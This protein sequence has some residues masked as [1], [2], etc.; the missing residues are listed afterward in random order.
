MPYVYL[1]P[2]R[3][4][5]DAALQELRSREEELEFVKQRI[6]QLKQTIAALGPLVST[7]TERVAQTA[8]LPDLCR[9]I[10]MSQPGAGFTAAIVAQHLANMGVDLSRYS[11]PLGVIHTTLARIPKPGNGF[12]R[13]Q[14]PDGP[15]YAYDERYLSDVYRSGMRGMAS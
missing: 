6:E 13:S 9:G 4:S 5:Y 2:Y 10:M 1:N 12:V 8:S 11:N 14:G 3:S 7:L 15:V